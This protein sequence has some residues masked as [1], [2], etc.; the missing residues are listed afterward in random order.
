MVKVDNVHVQM[1]VWSPSYQRLLNLKTYDGIDFPL[2]AW[3]FDVNG[4]AVFKQS[5]PA[6]KYKIVG[7]TPSIRVDLSATATLGIRAD[8]KRD[9]KG[10]LVVTDKIYGIEAM[11]I[12]LGR[13]GCTGPKDLEQKI[14]A[15]IRN[16][17]SRIW[18]FRESNRRGMANAYGFEDY[19]NISAE[20][21]QSD[22]DGFNEFLK[23]TLKSDYRI[24]TDKQ[25]RILRR[26][27]LSKLL[28]T[29]E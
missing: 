8:M 11:S 19:W 3:G 23:K 12:M 27:E 9:A 24:M 13:N 14:D 26:T 28:T 25:I 2:E 22:Y 10:V 18:I 15:L 4:N 29:E 20:P 21:P 6:L 7:T 5:D 17:M 1:C 16:D